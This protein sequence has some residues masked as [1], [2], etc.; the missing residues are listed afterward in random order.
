MTAQVC[1]VGG[2]P[3]G[4]TLA[5]ELAK[6]SV[7]VVVL[8]Q[9]GHFN[10]SFRGESVSPDSVWLL[11]RLGLLDRLDGTY[12]QMHHMEIIDSG[13]TVL[14]V[15]FSDFRYPHPYPVEL[16]QPALLSALA[17]AGREHPGFTLRQS[18]TAVALLREQG[19][20]GPVTGVRARTPD[21]DLVVRAALTVAADG[22]FSKVREMS[23][24]PYEKQ[25]L[26]RDVVWL[27]LPFP[28]EW[29]S[30][31]YRIRIRGGEHGL[32]IPTHPDSV[33]VGLNIPKGG[34]K[35]L[36]AQGLGA[37]HERLDRLAPE[38]STTVRKEV[39]AWSDTSMLDIFTTVVPR[40]SMPG[41][42]LM[43]DAAHT[44]TPIL[45]QGVNHAIIDAVTLAPLVGEALADDSAAA[46]VRAGEEFQRSREEAVRRS[47]A[48]QLRQERLFA[49]DGR[50][51]GL[52]RRSL[53]RVVD[54]NQA[55]QQKV[56]ARAYFQVQEPGAP[57][58][59][60]VVRQPASRP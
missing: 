55:L 31:T 20:S 22:R 37:L 34:L 43:G 18:A 14:S 44:L 24:L 42:V 25:P 57:V 2:G 15:D 23:G 19:D 6:R 8:E 50:L 60:R 3:A 46:L 59:P 54:R 21:G 5:V 27:R 45:G 30:H 26:D 16:P 33:R 48:L 40:W 39:K 47:R 41:L 52:A 38:L 12:A 49:L 7:S 56:L 58:A 28:E 36:R 29:D 1:V 53:Y 10:R 4:L 13:S 32:F 17:D 9:S 51:G 35:D 11:D